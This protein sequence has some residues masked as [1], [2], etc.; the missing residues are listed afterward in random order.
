MLIIIII[1]NF[2]FLLIDNDWS[3]VETNGVFNP[4]PRHGH[5]TVIH[6]VSLKFCYF[7]K[8]L[9]FQFYFCNSVVLFIIF[10]GHTVH[11]WRCHT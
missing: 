4:A 1:F 8:L 3:R 11:V 7:M 5:S 2:F 9:F 6:D 10:L